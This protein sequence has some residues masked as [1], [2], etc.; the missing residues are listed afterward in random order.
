MKTQFMSIEQALESGVI[1][2]PQ[3]I[4][5]PV[6]TKEVTLRDVVIDF[7]KAKGVTITD[8]DKTAKH[9]MFSIDGVI[10]NILHFKGGVAEMLDHVIK[11]HQKIEIMPAIKAG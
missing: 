7:G 6:F 8:I 10:K 1:L 4:Y 11:P 5:R 2:K 9:L 3:V